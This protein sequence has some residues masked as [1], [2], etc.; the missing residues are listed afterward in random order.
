MQKSSR[1]F[2]F[3]KRL[4]IVG[5]AIIAC[6]PLLALNVIGLAVFL[7]IVGN[8]VSNRHLR[9][10]AVERVGEDFG[11]FARAFDSATE[12]VDPKVLRATWDVLEPYV[13]FREGRVPLRPTD[14]LAVELF[15]DGM[16][17]DWLVD[18]V[19]AKSGRSIN[20]NDPR[21]FGCVETVG[22]LVGLITSQPLVAR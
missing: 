15:M 12:P 13:K 16:D 9:R 18:K 21:L 10:L 5:A 11:S 2:V 6:A 8:Y 22:D 17:F 19:A 14:R 7:Q 1:F 20:P 3:V 4:A